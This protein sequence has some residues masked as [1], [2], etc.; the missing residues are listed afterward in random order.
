M[1][2]DS[3]N[4]RK[5]ES[6]AVRDVQEG[7]GRC[8][9]LPLREAAELL[10]GKHGE[11]QVLMDIHFF[12]QSR[13]VNFLRMAIEDYVGAGVIDPAV[14]MPDALLETA[15]HYEEGAEKYSER[16][17][18]KGIP[19]HCYIDSGIRHYLKFRKGDN[20]ERHDRAF[21]WNMLGAIWTFRN[22]PE[23]DDLPRCEEVLQE[24]STRQTG[25][26]D[27]LVLA[28]AV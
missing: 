13:D 7:K 27:G 14:V 26:D 24:R 8:D 16:N 5:F 28:G 11:D 17:W 1:I 19:L 22:R 4:R 18:Q 20:D 2:K 23:M 6:G 9:L 12:M 3:G 21:I 25:T 10:G 15:M